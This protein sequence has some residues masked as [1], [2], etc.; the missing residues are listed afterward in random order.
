MQGKVAAHEIDSEAT[1]SDDSSKGE[2]AGTALVSTVRVSPEFAA[3]LAEQPAEPCFQKGGMSGA[4]VFAKLCKDEQLGALFCAPGNY[5]ITHAIAACGTPSYGGRTEGGMCSAADGFY[6]TSGEVAACSGTE[7]PGLANMVMGIGAASAAR[8][9]LLVL[10]SNASVAFED[11]EMHIQNI[12][13]QPI[14]QVFTKYGKRIITPSRVYEYGATA[15]RHLKSGVP[16]PVHLDFP[17]EV[18]DFRFTDASQLTDY[19]PASSYRTQSVAVPSARDMSEVVKLI[20]MAQRPILIAGHGVFHRGASEA[21]IAAAER[22]DLAVV[23]TGPNRGHFPDS[24][25]LSAD[26]SPGVLASVDLIIFVGQYSMPSR[27]EYQLNFDAKIIRIHPVVEDLGRNW[28][29]NLGIVGDERAFLEMLKDLLPPRKRDS[30]VGELLAARRAYEE[31][32]DY[33]YML[34]LK[35][36]TNGNVHPTVIG[37]EIFDFFF[38]G[39]LDPKQTVTGWGGFTTQPFIPPRLRANRPGQCISTMYQFGAVGVDLPMMVGVAA[40]VKEGT[41]VQ[42]A[43]KGAPVLLSCSD[44]DMGYGMFELETA[45]KYKLPLIAIVYNNNSWGSWITVDKSPRTLHLH[46]FSENIR[47]DRMAENL[48]VHGEYVRSAEQ[49]R[50]ALRRCYDITARESLPCLINV[51]AIREFTSS[52]MYPPGFSHNPEPGIGAHYH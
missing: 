31:E 34:G 22:N 37:R 36:S 4:E 10:A 2:S 47:Y 24:H 38:N 44:A 50:V 3:S 39:K 8:T 7:G 19:Y 30:W 11:R 33:Q 25:R 1:E 9:P 51:Q 32:L 52:A 49:L 14:T 16:G 27:V 42:R 17:R 12:Y 43:Y 5:A 23:V 21:L 40:A 29:L 15:F 20:N 28:P 48:G 13:Q 35:Y 18:T 45:A 6:R 41:G 26:L 46:L